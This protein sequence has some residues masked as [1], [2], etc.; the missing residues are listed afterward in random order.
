MVYSI[1]SS[2]IGH[3]KLTKD[4]RKRTFYLPIENTIY[5]PSTYGVKEQKKISNK[6]M[7]KRTDNNQK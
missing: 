3:L 5:V 7:K 6:E 2:K 4:E 1:K